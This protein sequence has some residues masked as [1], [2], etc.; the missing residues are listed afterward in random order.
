ML[1]RRFQ[2]DRKTNRRRRYYNEVENEIGKWAGAHRVYYYHCNLIVGLRSDLR[3]RSV[4][5]LRIE[6]VFRLAM[7]TTFE[8]GCSYKKKL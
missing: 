6:F 7:Q 8:F 5:R 2:T 4:S 3:A 1:E